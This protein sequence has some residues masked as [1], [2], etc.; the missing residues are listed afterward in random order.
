VLRRSN[1]AIAQVQEGI[2]VQVNDSWL[3]LFGYAEPSALVGQPVMTCHR[4]DAGAPQ[5]RPRGLPARTLE[6]PPA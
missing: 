3:E 2:V 6:R 5:G 4:R 1:D